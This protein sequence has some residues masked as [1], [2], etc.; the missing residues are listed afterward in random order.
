MLVTFN[1]KYLQLFYYIYL[2]KVP[3]RITMKFVNL[4]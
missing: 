1:V 4:Q 3:C 2:I